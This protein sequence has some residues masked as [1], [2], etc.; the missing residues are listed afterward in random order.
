MLATSI[1]GEAAGV[2]DAHPRA[3][4]DETLAL[5]AAEVVAPALLPAP[6][7]DADLKAKRKAAKEKKQAKLRYCREQQLLSPTA[8]LPT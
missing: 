8:D 5:P 6:Q 3:K 7:A 1:A 2:G 4:H